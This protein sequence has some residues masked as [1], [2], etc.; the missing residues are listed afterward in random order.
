MFV[1][2]DPKWHL[3]LEGPI[4]LVLNIVPPEPENS[5]SSAETQR[6]TG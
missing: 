1:G 5:G 6:K 4:Y 3:R 2:L